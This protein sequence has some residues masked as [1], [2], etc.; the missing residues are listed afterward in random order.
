MKKFSAVVEQINEQKKNI[1]IL[2]TGFN[3]LDDFLE[4]GFLKKELV[5]IGAPTGKGK[6]MLAGSLFRNVAQMGYKCAY[7]SLEISNEMVVSRLL[8]AEA[9]ISPTRIMIK[10]LDEGESEI[11]DRARATLSVYEEFM[12]FYDNLY[13]YSEIE[14]EMRQGMY[15]YVIIDFVQN[16][17]HK[18]MPDEYQRLSFV[19]LALQKL[20]KELNCCIVALSQLSN[21]M[22]KDKKAS[23]MEYKGSGS[24]ATACDLGFYIVPSLVETGFGLELRKNRRGPSGR[25][26]EFDVKQPGGLVVEL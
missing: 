2:P 16:V 10:T 23:H 11:T 14:K 24:I 7:F 19:S 22:A 3:W 9:N 1:E 26:F 21:V 25:R 12:Y 17:M 6:S 18:P 8:G 4:G 15:D 13:E 20:A 5:V